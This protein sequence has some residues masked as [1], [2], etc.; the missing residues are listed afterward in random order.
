[1]RL[2][3]A[4]ASD[5]PILGM[6]E[7]NMGP[8]NSSGRAVR[9]IVEPVGLAGALFGGTQ[10]RVLALLFG[11]PHRSFYAN[12]V[13]ALARSGTGAVQ[14]ELARLAESGLVTVRASGNQRH[15][16]ADPTS[17]IFEELVAIVRKTV[18]LADPL[19]AALADFSDR[20]T[21]A[22]VY[23]SI[24]KGGDRASSDVDLM[25]VSDDLSYAELFGALEEA[26][27]AIGRTINPTIYSMEEWTRRRERQD[28]FV[29]RVWS[30][31][32]VWLFGGVD[33]LGA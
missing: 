18:G 33:E 13:I 25:I 1:M 5:I 27:R 11:Q 7:P 29:K 6:I 19:R 9:S 32:K 10:Q 8:N 31:P 23:G 14:R 17:P 4:A 28:G 21:G 15:Y 12:E 24:A 3:R 26:G 30:Q 2:Y 16:Q 22:F 20:I